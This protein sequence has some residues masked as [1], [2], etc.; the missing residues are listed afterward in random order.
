[1]KGKEKIRKYWTEALAEH[2][3]LHFE[4]LQTFVGVNSVVLCYKGVRGRDEAEV[5][6]F[7]S[8]GKVSKSF[9]NHS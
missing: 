7:D 4:L 2:E 5:F 3:D 8:L 9:A 1:L 6:I